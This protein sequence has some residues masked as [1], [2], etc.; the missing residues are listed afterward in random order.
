MLHLLLCQPRNL[1]RQ[2][3]LLYRIE[4][5]LLLALIYIYLVTRIQPYLADDSVIMQTAIFSA[6][7]YALLLLLN[8]T[9]VLR[10]A[11]PRQE[12]LKVF[13][14]QPLDK[15]TLLKLTGYYYVKYQLIFFVGLLPVLTAL[16]I[17][18]WLIGTGLLIF[19]LL[20]SL[21]IFLW[22]FLLFA[23]KNRTKGFWIINLLAALFFMMIWGWLLLYNNRPLVW[24]ATAVLILL[25]GALSFFFWYKLLPPALERL[26][27][28]TERF[29]TSSIRWSFS[30]SWISKSW[31][32]LLRKEALTLWRNPSY[33]RLKG[34]TVLVYTGALGYFALYDAAPR[35]DEMILTAMLIIWLH[36]A[37]H[38]SDKYV[39]PE[40][41]W[42]VRT[43]PVRFFSLW[44]A[45]LS[46]EFLYVLFLLA[47]Q[48]GV[49]LAAGAE[50]SVQVNILGLLLLFSLLVLTTMINFQLLFYDNPRL[51]GYAY[52]FTV[53]FFTVMSINYRFVGPVIT[54]FM[55]V[56]IF[57]K[58]RKYFY[59]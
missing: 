38:F 7:I 31:D 41:D 12:G 46:V 14:A 26:W 49:L 17:R 9:F 23:Y 48:W 34:I 57:Y 51:A 56:L 44:L 32:A 25:A 50:S 39:L 22:H 3:G 42:F 11:L 5:V 20:I 43:L 53:L 1:W 59:A 19:I 35:Y 13:Y 29:Y 8:G 15:T 47:A 55:M 37:Q 36:Y 52:H 21:I 54:L 28:P 18:Q 24:V 27:P 16:F 30:L 33:R 4:I 6:G 2:L 45:K 40:A 58:T 10:F